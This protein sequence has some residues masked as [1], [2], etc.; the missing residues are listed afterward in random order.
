MIENAAPARLFWLLTP[1]LDVEELRAA[2][3]AALRLGDHRKAADYFQQA[4][5]STSD[6][7]SLNG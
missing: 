7:G 6:I 1:Y 3:N 4:L 5:E 2:G